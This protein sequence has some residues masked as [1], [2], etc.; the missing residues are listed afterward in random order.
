[1]SCSSLTS[2]ISQHERS[3]SLPCS[4]ARSAPRHGP[5]RFCRSS[6]QRRPLSS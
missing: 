1:L 4:L 6:R 3:V 5:A 2:L